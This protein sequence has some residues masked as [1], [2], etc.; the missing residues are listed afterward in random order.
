MKHRQ[1]YY[2]RPMGKPIRT[3][4]W[5]RVAAILSVLAVTTLGA[6]VLVEWAVGCGETYIDAK[7]VT[8]ANEC[9]FI[10]TNR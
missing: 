1:N 2:I 10:P 6:I 5:Q 7:G 8:H 9:V 4:W 3:P